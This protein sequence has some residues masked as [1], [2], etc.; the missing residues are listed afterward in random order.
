MQ[1]LIWGAVVVAILLV[2]FLPAYHA[3]TSKLHE[4]AELGNSTS[5]RHALV[6]TPTP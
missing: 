4:I 3:V 1:Y 5:T 2:M 6:V